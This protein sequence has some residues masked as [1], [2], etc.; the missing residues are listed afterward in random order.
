MKS[1]GFFSK[2]AVRM[3]VCC[4]GSFAQDKLLRFSVQEGRI[5]PFAGRGRSF[6]VC[7]AC[8][9]DKNILKQVLRAK[10]IPRDKKYVQAW[11]EEIRTYE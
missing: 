8:L 3:C 5:V 9:N 11:L 1:D 10:N 2:N 6:Y 4:R 7:H